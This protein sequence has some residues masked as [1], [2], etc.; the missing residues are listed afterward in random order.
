MKGF[1]RLET[2]TSSILILS[3]SLEAGSGL[4]GLGGVGAETR[5]EGLQIGDL[6][7]LLGVV[8]QQALTGLGAAV[9]YSS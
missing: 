9:M 7:L 5:H 4:A 8:G 3:I 6:G 1:C 2:F